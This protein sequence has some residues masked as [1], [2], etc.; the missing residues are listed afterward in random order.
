MKNIYLHDASI[1]EK[2]VD[3][4][5]VTRQPGGEV[6]FATHCNIAH[7]ADIEQ[8]A[9][10]CE[11]IYNG[12]LFE[13]ETLPMAKDNR[14]GESYTYIPYAH[15]SLAVGDRIE[16]RVNKQRRLVL[17]R[18]HTLTHIVL[19]A[20]SRCIKEFEVVATRILEDGCTSRIFF[21]CCDEPTTQQLGQLNALC[22]AVIHADEP[23]E[24]VSNSA[25]DQ[26][27]SDLDRV[28]KIGGDW[29]VRVC[30]GTHVDRTGLIKAFSHDTARW[31]A[32]RKC[33]E[34]RF[35]ISDV[36]TSWYADA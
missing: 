12:V 31:N 33:W 21:R 11:F 29:D 22:R 25:A 10:E 4:T 3:V 14:N 23:V 16:F 9:D 8:P 6:H 13:A 36:W 26:I 5:S 7:A 19:G 35:R 32:Q 17:C 1:T 18:S 20:M 30:P 15:S 2:E 27:D 24:S 28:V 34:M